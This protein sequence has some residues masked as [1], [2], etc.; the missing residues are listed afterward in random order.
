MRGA[1]A[2]QALVL[3]VAAVALGGCASAV[4][5]DSGGSAHAP[6]TSAPVPESEAGPTPETGPTPAPPTPA[7]PTPASPEQDDPTRATESARPTETSAPAD[8]DESA[9]PSPSGTEPSETDDPGVA[10]PADDFLPSPDDEVLWVRIGN[11]DIAE[12]V[13]PQGL[14]EEGTIDP[15]AGEVIWFTGYDR[16]APGQVGTAV[17][18]GH[19]SYGDRPDAFADL[20]DVAVGDRVEVGY[21]GGEVLDLEV[22]STD[23][24]DKAELRHSRDVWGANDDVRR[25]A[26][27][28]CDDAFGLRD[29][30]HRAANFVA[31]AEVLG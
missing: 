1:R 4:E 8:A 19:V 10:V 13:V 30:G 21:T 20:A 26:V 9:D 23:L 15:A 17:V 28:T 7:S 2:R 29:D 27:I 11:V 25:V 22:V 12:D 31:V 5:D 24:V 16:V 18:A 6:T 14:S 3:V